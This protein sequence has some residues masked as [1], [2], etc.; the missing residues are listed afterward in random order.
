MEGYETE[1]QDNHY[2]DVM[3]EE[4]NIGDIGIPDGASAIFA[5]RTDVTNNNYIADNDD[6]QAK[7]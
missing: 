7:F 6:K 4:V 1:D 3:E 2:K 5:N